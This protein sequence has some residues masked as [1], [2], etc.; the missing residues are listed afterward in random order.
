MILLVDDDVYYQ[1]A[2]ERLLPGLL[3]VHGPA[4]ALEVARR[5][6]RITAVVLDVH[7]PGEGSGI[8][9]LPAL[10][11]AL[12]GVPVVVVSARYDPR[13]GRAALGAG[14]CAYV[15]KGDARL[16]AGCLGPGRCPLRRRG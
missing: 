15:E 16:L 6:L 1:R 10:R 9:A 4:E 14:A 3:S 5:G 2:L 7:F 8:E 11:R 13:D 12:P